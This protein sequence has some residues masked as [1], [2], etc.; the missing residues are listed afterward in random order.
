MERKEIVIFANIGLDSCLAVSLIMDNINN[1]NGVDYVSPDFDNCYLQDESLKRGG[2]CNDFNEE[3]EDQFEKIRIDEEH[4]S[5]VIIFFCFEKFLLE[6]TNE[7]IKEQAVIFLVD[8]S[9]ETNAIIFNKHSKTG[10]EYVCIS[11]YYCAL[12]VARMMKTDYRQIHYFN[13]L[14]AASIIVTEDYLQQASGLDYRIGKKMRKKA[15]KIIDEYNA[16]LKIVYNISNDPE[17]ISKFNFEFM[18]QVLN[19]KP[20]P[21]IAKIFSKE[22][23]MA[24]ETLRLMNKIIDLGNGIGLVKTGSKNFFKTDILKI[25]A[26]KKFCFCS[27]QYIKDLELMT[28]SLGLR[29]TL[30]LQRGPFVL[31]EILGKN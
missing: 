17:L 29:D 25:M 1:L 5:T 7:L 22:K 9:Q 8:Y 4:V 3:D 31:D 19:Q 2:E 24:A 28:L 18:Y 30:Y 26:D 16:L 10:Q 21:Y 12:S 14:V 11:E 15:E 23:E 20:N 13:I 27:I 6:A